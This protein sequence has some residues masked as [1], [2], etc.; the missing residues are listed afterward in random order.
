MLYMA[1]KRH[2]CDFMMLECPCVCNM[3]KEISDFARTP[4]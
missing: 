3:A 4:E 1:Y 2:I